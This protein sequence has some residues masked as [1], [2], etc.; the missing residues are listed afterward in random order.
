MHDEL[1][2]TL[3][4][5]ALLGDLERASQ[6]CAGANSENAITIS[7]TARRALKS[8]D[9]IVWAVNP[10]NDTADHLLEYLGQYAAE[11]LCSAEIRCRLQLP[12]AIPARMIP[13]D[14]RHHLFL[15][16]KEA[17]HNVVKHAGASEVCL[18]AE[19]SETA[20]TLFIRDNGRG[21]DEYSANHFANGIH[22]IE[23][24]LTQVGGRAR[25]ESHLGEG[26]EVTLVLP[27]LAG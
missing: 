23:E 15:A 21:F 1:G 11:Y 16:T 26:S 13:A 10:R 18:R 22:N 12:E 27:W 2:A 9:E 7:E 19:I 8:L 24:R 14:A 4:R 5:I 17:L 20:L 6:T 3:T 25:I